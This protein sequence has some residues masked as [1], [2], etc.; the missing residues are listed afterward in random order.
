[1]VDTTA[2]GRD[3]LPHSLYIA[4]FYSH[5]VPLHRASQALILT[6]VLLSQYGIL[7]TLPYQAYCLHQAT[8][9]V[10]PLTPREAL[11]ERCHARCFVQSLC[12]FLAVILLPQ[13]V[14][15]DRY[16]DLTVQT[17]LGLFTAVF[18][19]CH[20]HAVLLVDARLTLEEERA[21][22]EYVR[23]VPLDQRT[24]RLVQL[25]GLGEARYQ[26]TA[27]EKF[28]QHIVAPHLAIPYFIVDARDHAL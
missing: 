16:A 23:Q 8:R 14:Q 17:L 6:L 2:T 4:V 24:L 26:L 10:A 11:R 20:T 15:L 12:V 3:S 28:D 9:T 1:M 19:L 7:Y 21:V 13:L 22:S 5:P 27:L 18:S 25:V